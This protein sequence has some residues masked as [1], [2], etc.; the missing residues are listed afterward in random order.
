MPAGAKGWTEAGI[1]SLLEMAKAAGDRG[2]E[3]LWRG[4]L[5][6]ELELLGRL[7]EQLRIIEES[8]KRWRQPTRGPSGCGRS[9]ESA[10]G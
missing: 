8:S 2:P 10:P 9:P 5:E 7:Q 3:E 4:Q 6:S 1:A